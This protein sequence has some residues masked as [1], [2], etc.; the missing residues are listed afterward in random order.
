ER[1]RQTAPRPGA[2][3]DGCRADGAA[4]LPGHR[5]RRLLEDGQAPEHGIGLVRPH[6]GGRPAVSAARLGPGL[7]GPAPGG[8]PPAGPLVA[9]GRSSADLARR[10]P[11]HCPGADAGLSA[12]GAGA[13]DR[14]PV[15]LGR[16]AGRRAV[17]HRRPAGPARRDGQRAFRVRQVAHQPAEHRGRACLRRPG[18]GGRAVD[19]RRAGKAGAAPDGARPV[20]AQGGGQCNPRGAAG[21]GRAVRD[22]HRRGRP[23][24]PVRAGRCHRRRHRLRP[25]EAGFQLRERLR[26]PVRAVAAHR[27]HGTGRRFRGPGGGHQDPLHAD[28]LAQRPR[29]DRA[30]READ[31]R[32]DREPVAGRPQGAGVH[33]S[34]GR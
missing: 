27:R 30:Q 2:S 29:I 8:G 7:P 9:A 34:L 11:L 13:P 19:F 16:V 21:G 20:A 33:R 3:A 25:A 17:G 24:S 5:L 14:T 10:H 6:H 18:D 23:H 15:L 4:G 32:T 26:H 31:H 12:F 28:P 22:V 1:D